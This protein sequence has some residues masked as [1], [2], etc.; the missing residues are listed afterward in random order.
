L[1]G[2]IHKSHRW[3]DIRCL[4]C[5]D[6]WPI[7]CTPRDTSW[8]AKWLKKRIDGCIARHKAEADDV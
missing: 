3:G 4:V 1:I 7:P 8:Y 5:G 6:H 2:E